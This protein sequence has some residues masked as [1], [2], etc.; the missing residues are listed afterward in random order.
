MWSDDEEEGGQNLKTHR[1]STI[2]LNYLQLK[3]LFEQRRMSDPSSNLASFVRGVWKNKADNSR[4]EGEN[5]DCCN[6]MEGGD[7]RDGMLLAVMV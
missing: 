4:S 5:L 1:V 3:I 2:P 7:P 6:E